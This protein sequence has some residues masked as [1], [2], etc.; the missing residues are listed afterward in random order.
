MNIY[1]L[2]AINRV[3]GC[4]WIDSCWLT[5]DGAKERAKRLAYGWTSASVGSG[6]CTRIQEGFLEDARPCDSKVPA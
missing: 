1:I 4:P 2:W 5:E 6:Y 3:T